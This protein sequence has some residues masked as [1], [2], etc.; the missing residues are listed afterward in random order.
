MLTPCGRALVYDR[1]GHEPEGENWI[2]IVAWHISGKKKLKQGFFVN[3][4]GGPTKLEMTESATT[5]MSL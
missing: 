4:L 1:R 3:P 2:L 5:A